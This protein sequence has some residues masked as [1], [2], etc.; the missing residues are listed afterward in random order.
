MTQILNTWAALDLRKR[1]IVVLAMAAAALA[2]YFV[3]QIATQPR[4]T[5]LYAQLEES[6]AGDVVRALEQ[7]NVPYEVRSGAIFVDSTQRDSLRLTL[8][9]EG[10]PA[11]GPKGYELLD[12]LTGFGTTAQMFDAAYWRAKEGELARTILSSPGITGARVHI[13][14]A[15]ANPFLHDVSVTA[16]VFLTSASGSIDPDLARAM[17]YL[18]ASAVPQMEPEEVSII[19][20]KGR[21]VSAQD[22]ATAANTAEDRGD[23]LRDRVQRLV[24]ARVG[25]GNAV[26]EV[27]VDTVTETESI[28]ERRFDP[29]GRVAISTDTEERTRQSEEGAANITVASNLPDGAAAGG[30]PNTSQDSETRERVNYE[31]SETTR[32]ITRSPGAIRRL[33]VAVLVNGT[34]APDANGQTVF[35]PLP[36]TELIALRELVAAAVGFDK[37]RGDEI[38]IR[39]MA[40]EQTLASGTAGVAEPWYARAFDLMALAQMAVLGLVALLIGLFVLRPILASRNAPAP[41]QLDAASASPSDPAPALPTAPF[42]A[43]LD[44]ES[45]DLPMMMA[46][47]SSF[48]KEFGGDS[49][50]DSDPI[51]RLR[52]LIEA[53]KEETVEVLRTWLDEKEEAR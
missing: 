53:R 33:T 23:Q 25:R 12:S 19:D 14:N 21:L 35:T 51:E 45:G 24:E 46:A 7:R 36:D 2:L 30:D 32:E 39:S 15:A 29:N 3:L 26:V 20:S 43:G 52:G 37:D 38:T 6:A 5:L 22:G 4:M 11:N 8:A 41:L 42:E 10:L 1:F 34:I 48:D 13:A 47:P 9:S 31:V 49:V 16:S 40:F 27:S 18:V 17:R 28:L 50:L 44:D